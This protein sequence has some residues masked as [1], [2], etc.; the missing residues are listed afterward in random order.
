MKDNNEFTPLNG[1]NHLTLIHNLLIE[2]NDR[3]AFFHIGVMTEWL[4]EM[5]RKE[6]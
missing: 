2:G 6:K 4:A 5:I 3:A 1:L